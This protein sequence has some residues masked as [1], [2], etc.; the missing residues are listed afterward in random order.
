M[1]ISNKKEP[2]LLLIGDVAAFYA[3]LWLMLLIRYGRFPAE[4][5]FLTHF[6]PFTILF[7]FWLIVFFIAGLYEKH[8]LVLKNKL[9]ARIF[10]AEIV[11]IV[12]A[13]LFFYLIPYFNITPKLN[14]F[15][16]LVISFPLILLW[17][18]ASLELLGIRRRARA[19]LIGRGRE[20]EELLREVNNN[21]RYF[22]QFVSRIDLS[23]ADPRELHTDILNRIYAEDI[24][25]VVI[26]IYDE[27]VEQVLP[28]LF[29]LIFSKV[30]FIDMHKMYEEIFDRVPLSIITYNWFLQN[31]TLHP[32]DGYDLVKRIMDIA[33][34]LVVGIFSLMLY[35]FAALAIKLDDGGPVFITQKRIGKDNRL[36]RIHKFRTMARIDRGKEV[37]KSTNTITR[38]G[39][40][41]RASRIDELPQ[42][43]NV[44]W[45]ELSLIGPR[46]E[47]PE[48]SRVYENEVP[49][50]NI[51]HLIKPGLSG[52]AQMYHEEPGKF[53]VASLPTRDKLS[54]DL[55]YIKNRSL[56]LDFKIALKTVK[57]FFTRAGK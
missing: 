43:W 55:F 33:I 35:P 17:R 26:D 44:L 37:L 8:T 20:T 12:T 30:H 41:L 13:V 32:K 21:A 10:N 51:R 39:R 2:I 24:S 52:W 23:T 38:V 34:A 11:N 6:A 53:K 28:Q 4:E 56:F 42:L 54:Y 40:F 3:S 7:A 18:N 57:V 19:L 1:R 45:G 48:I 36:I 49:Y 5:L 9:P 27:K 50:Y 47:I 31:L 16:Y 15:I 14:L 22:I 29:N 46:P 25:W